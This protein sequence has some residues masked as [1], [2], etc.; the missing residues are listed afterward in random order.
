MASGALDEAIEA[1]GSAAEWAGAA[2]DVSLMIRAQLAQ[3]HC[4]QSAGRATEAGDVIAQCEAHLAR[5]K[6]PRYIAY[7]DDFP[8]TATRKIAKQRMI[9]AA[10]DLRQGAFDR[11]DGVWR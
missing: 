2:G 3:A 10:E 8:R 5:F 9:K 6:W 1:F 4:Y 7:V 11:I